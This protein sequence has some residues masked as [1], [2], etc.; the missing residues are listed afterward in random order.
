M[1]MLVSLL[2]VLTA[3]CSYSAFFSVSFRMPIGIAPITTICGAILWLYLFGYFDLLWLG[4]LL[5]HLG[6]IAALAVCVYMGKK[7]GLRRTFLELLEPGFVLFSAVSLVLILVL[8]FRKPMF[9]FWD[10]FSFWGTASKITVLHDTLYPAV[11]SSMYGKLAYPPAVPL[12]SYL[13]HFFSYEFADWGAMAGYDVMLCACFAAVLSSLHKKQAYTG[14]LFGT[15]CLLLPLL[16]ETSSIIGGMV[17]VYRTL[18]SEIFLGCLFGAA[19]AVWFSGTEK[20]TNTVVAF[21]AILTVLCLTK[22]VGLVLSLAAM[23]IAGMDLLLFH[24]KEFTLFRLRSWAAIGVALLILVVIAGMAYPS[25]NRYFASVTEIDRT[26]GDGAAGLTMGG[27]LLTGFQELLGI[28]RTE[29]FTSVLHRMAGAFFTEKVSAFGSGFITSLVIMAICVGAYFARPKGKRAA[30][31]TYFF[32]GCLGLGGM[33]LFHLFA[34][35]YVFGSESGLNLI[36]Y[37]R[38]LG[39]YYFGWMLGALTL[40]IPHVQNKQSRAASLGIALAVVLVAFHTAPISRTLF[41]PYIA[42]S[43][44]RALIHF[45]TEEIREQ[46]NTEDRVFLVSQFDNAN[47]WYQ[48][49]YE[50]EPIRLLPMLGNVLAV[51][52]DYM[53][54]PVGETVISVEE[55]RNWLQ[56]QGCTYIFIDQA[57]EYDGMGYTDL[58][59]DHL[60]GYYKEGVRLYR[61]V[62]KNGIY[63]FEPCGKAGVLA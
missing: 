59:T 8:F 13:F 2:L 3:I 56:K 16:F 26:A 9:V 4:G 27:V 21:A 20:N 30:A 17:F 48:Y 32:T 55:Y 36:D 58:F 50:L 54:D 38:Y 23:L 61:A 43:D 15:V 22:D 5:W 25:W 41:A 44:G 1:E 29:Y 34:Y 47:R 60:D 11:E 53:G 52:E 40:L 19:L 57:S 49:A 33:M 37:T 39:F 24:R 62:I 45:R 7:A 31:F 51:N 42:N 63:Q 28:G 10:E 12:L 35:V 18:L 14:F 46:C 6:A